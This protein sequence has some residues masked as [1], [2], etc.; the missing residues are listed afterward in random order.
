M[1][2]ESERGQTEVR[3]NFGVR[4]AMYGDSIEEWYWEDQPK[5]VKVL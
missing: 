2:S 1:A 4:T 5:K 3:N